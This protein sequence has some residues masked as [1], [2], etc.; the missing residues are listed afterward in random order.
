MKDELPEPDQILEELADR[1][2]AQIDRRAPVA[3]EG[4]LEELVRYHRFLL[5][6]YATQTEDGGAFSYAEVSGARWHAPH[7]KWIHQYRRLFDR[8]AERIPD[9]QRFVDSLSYVP[10]RLLDAE[11]GISLS[12][13]VV[14]GILDLMPMLMHAI[15]AWVTRRSIIEGDGAGGAE[16]NALSGSD[17]RS[18][19]STMLSLVGAWE[20]VLGAASDTYGWA[21]EN[22]TPPE[23]VWKR[24]KSSWRFLR[25]HL[26][27]T[28][29]CLAVA[30][31]NGD[32]TSA[33]LF[34][35]A[36]VRW[37]GSALHDLQRE[38]LDRYPWLLMPE[39][40][41]GDWAAAGS[42][43]GVINHPYGADPEPNS[44]FAEIVHGA[45][46]DV[47]LVTTSLMLVWSIKGGQVGDLA[48][49][50]AR[51]ML[52]GAAE[53][54]ME[55]STGG[56]TFQAIME[57]LIRLQWIGER[58]EEN[59]HGEW[60]DK[61]VASMDN[62]RQASVVPGRVYSPTTMHDR[63]QL[64]LGDMALIAA[65]APADGL[66]TLADEI[67]A[68]AAADALTPNG[69]GSLRQVLSQ[70]DRY[71]HMLGFDRAAL[72]R[73]ISAAEPNANPAAAIANLERVMTEIAS[74]IARRR[75]ERLL[76]QPVDPGAME[77]LRAAIE[78]AILDDTPVVPLFDQVEL[79]DAAEGE[80][81]RRQVTFTGIPK[82]RLVRPEM[83]PQSD[84][85]TEFIAKR[86]SE[87]A[88]SYVRDVF[89]RRPRVPV[90]VAAPPESRIF[91][92]AMPELVRRVGRRPVL[93]VAKQDSRRLL[94]AMRFGR[95]DPLTGLNVTHER[96]ARERGRHALTIE[97]VEIFA[98]GIEPGTAWLTSA[99]HLARIG[100]APAG[101]ER[102]SLVFTPD[103]DEGATQGTLVIGFSQVLEWSDDPVL[104]IHFPAHE[105]DQNIPS[106]D[107]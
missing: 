99:R 77:E 22:A 26:A 52:G 51:E 48:A 54:P 55:P 92:D 61:Q 63:E 78:A 53:D 59:T 10:Y 74:S 8:A 45:R 97:G 83:E 100:Y 58:Y 86:S 30:V 41:D 40:L 20:T 42:R 73:A 56:L 68:I 91:W 107:P 31:W 17:A 16:R 33:S 15:E 95:S 21:V 66:G 39:L 46:Q 14:E 27:N 34:R 44:L 19:A 1:V 35:E 87:M 25:Q 24:F 62:M 102:V 90:D 23:E 57:G 2:I 98:L 36:L 93:I 104:E 64:V 71:R 5:G 85:W 79:F 37:P 94:N 72:E 80:G 18:L 101:N 32:A 103:E 67:D 96:V 29:Y 28:A 43:S 6:L 9:E 84:H 12:S 50:T 76:T 11:P 65:T 105:D 60:L 69:D 49:Q 89:A 106:P 82:G 13:P 75:R 4:A 38:E 70:I 7:L 3:F 81:D 88:L 47:L